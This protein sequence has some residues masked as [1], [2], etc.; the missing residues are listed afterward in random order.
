MELKGGK[1]LGFRALGQGSLTRLHLTIS[2]V[3]ILFCY[4]QIFKYGR[5][6]PP[7]APDSCPSIS[8]TQK[9]THSV[10]LQ[11]GKN[12]EERGLHK[13]DERRVTWK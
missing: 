6:W 7:A 3:F 4:T 1:F 9:A 11:L 5:R 8:V 10:L 2:P 12:P 13:R